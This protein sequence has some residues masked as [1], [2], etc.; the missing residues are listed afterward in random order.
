MQSA[1]AYARFNED[2]AAV[3]EAQHDFA[4]AD[5]ASFVHSS[6]VL[7]GRPALVGAYT[8]FCAF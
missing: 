2:G 6:P 8:T 3:E 7:L 1:R 5:P 4:I